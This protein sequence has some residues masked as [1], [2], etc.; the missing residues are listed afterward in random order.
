MEQVRFALGSCRK[1]HTTGPDALALLDDLRSANVTTPPK[2]PQ[3]LV[4]GGDQIYADEVSDT[5]LMMLTDAGG[6]LLGQEELPLSSH[7]VDV[8]GPVAAELAHEDDQGGGLHERRY[9]QSSDGARRVPRDVSVRV[10]GRSVADPLSG[11]PVV[12]A[13]EDV[14]DL[15]KHADDLGAAKKLGRPCSLSGRASS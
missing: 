7:R 10:V 15:A 4:L 2:S 5:L 8:A 6:T 1:T 3:L 9:A 12:P 13:V 11:M 14:L